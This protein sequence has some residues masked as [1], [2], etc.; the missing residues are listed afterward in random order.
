MQNVIGNRE[1]RACVGSEVK[2]KCNLEHY[3]LSL[4][5]KDSKRVQFFSGREIDDAGQKSNGVM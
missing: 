2:K 3:N 1:D 4:R 5:R